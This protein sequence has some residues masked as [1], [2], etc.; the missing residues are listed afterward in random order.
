MEFTVQNIKDVI[1]YL[2]ENLDDLNSVSGLQDDLIQL[3]NKVLGKSFDGI[4]ETIDACN[5]TLSSYAGHNYNAKVPLSQRHDLYTD[6][7]DSLRHSINLLGEKLTQSTIT[8][9]HLEDIF[10][11]ISSFIVTID[12][13]GLITSVNNAVEDVTGF[14]KQEL[15][16]KYLSY[17]ISLDKDLNVILKRQNKSFKCNFKTSKATFVPAEMQ[18]FPFKRGDEKTIGYAFI[19][20]D[21]SLEKN[22][23]AKINRRNKEIEKA[24]KKLEELNEELKNALFKAEESDRLKSAFLANVSHELRTPLNGILGFASLLSNDSFDKE[25]KQSFIDMIDMQGKHLLRII[26]DLIDIARIEADEVGLVYKEVDVN[27]LFDKQ[28]LF[29]INNLTLKNKENIEIYL[30][31]GFV[32]ND[33]IIQTDKTRLIQVL[34]NLV[35]NSIKYTETGR[36]NIGYDLV[37]NDLLI[38]VSDTGMGIS[39]AY[40]NVIFQPFTQADESVTRK[41]DGMGLGLA[42]TKR[43]VEALGGKIW[44]ES[45]EGKGTTFYFTHPIEVVAIDNIPFDDDSDFLDCIDFSPFVIFIVEDDKPGLIYLQRLVELTGAEVIA[46][47][48]GKDALEVFYEHPEIDLILMDVQLPGIDGL[49]LTRLFKS[50]RNVP[51]IAQTAFTSS[52]DKERCLKAGCDDYLTKPISAKQLLTIIDKYLDQ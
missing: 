38:Y 34:N 29:Y 4:E 28:L 30:S 40:Q 10:N 39:E 48:D 20:Q 36:I 23:Q 22:F 5:A 18:L 41:H 26:E 44:F 7:W 35:S 17:I 1:K 50:E 49:Q 51:I 33:F 27:D 11:A 46:V 12:T 31:K 47:G 13:S 25:K 45:E 2:N 42:I 24:N 37:D 3:S 9:K 52:V 6:L 16:G 21:L 8:R 43:L 19:A 15:Q 14:A 32:D